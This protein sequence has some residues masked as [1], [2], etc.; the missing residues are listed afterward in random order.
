MEP[1][2]L[3]A[4]KLAHAVLFVISASL[5]VSYKIYFYNSNL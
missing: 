3:E 1:P 2:F 5:I 4:I